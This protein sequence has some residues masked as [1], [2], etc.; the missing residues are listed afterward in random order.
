MNRE[1][2][3]IWNN[4]QGGTKR[5]LCLSCNSVWL[6][7]KQ[8]HLFFALVFFFRELSLKSLLE[9]CKIHDNTTHF[10]YFR[11]HATSAK[12]IDWCEV[13][14]VSICIK[15]ASFTVILEKGQG[16]NEP[17]HFLFFFSPFDFCSLFIVEISNGSTSVK[18]FHNFH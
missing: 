7:R 5:A 15:S 2:T 3:R 14:F 16:R 6:C 9:L 17:S 18:N 12:K 10:A 4:H 13:I 8:D 1:P 11:Y